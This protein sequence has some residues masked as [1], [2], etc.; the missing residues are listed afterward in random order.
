LPRAGLVAGALSAL[1]APVPAAALT[2]QGCIAALPLEAR[3]GQVLLGMSP[4]AAGAMAGVHD[5]RLTGWAPIGT[6]E[7]AQLPALL[8]TT[9]ANPIPPLLAA[10][11]EGG[12]VQ[13]FSPPLAP[14]PDAATL[15]A[16]ASEAEVRSL[17]A[18]HGSELR[19]F[20]LSLAFAPV[21]DVG[22]SAGIANRTF[23][24]DPAIV[25]RYARATA[26]GYLAAGV[27]P[28]FKHFPG[29]GHASGDTHLGAATV[30]PL[31][32]LRAVDL[33]PFIDAV[34]AYG[35]RVGIMV[36]HLAVPGLTGDEPAS[37]SM[38]AITG[39]LRHELGF[40][41]LVVSDS[42]DMGAVRATI[43]PAEAV[44]R[45]LAAGGDLAIIHAADTDGVHRFVTGAVRAGTLSEERLNEAVDRVLQL[46]GVDPCPLV[47]AFT[48]TSSTTTSTTAPSPTTP[49]PGADTMG[50]A[51]SSGAPPGPPAVSPVGTTATVTGP[52][53]PSMTAT[54][55]GRGPSTGQRRITYLTLA[56]GV[57]SLGLAVVLARRNRR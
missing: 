39:L 14:L 29:H 8:A 1:T 44:R 49:P 37:V 41:G 34:A 24:T 30:P 17:F 23:G 57:S 18:T 40:S 50:R 42:F 36:G 9:A 12:L 48:T 33:R 45:F 55:T 15:A 38:A 52:Q 46:K 47:A 56:G 4:T 54:P 10:D 2:P 3:V 32:Q 25:S 35:D 21:A 19:R 7:V 27:T 28:V 26:D 13:R 51:P 16:T 31:E 20:G 43:G 11:E 5:G 22:D 6:V 53:D